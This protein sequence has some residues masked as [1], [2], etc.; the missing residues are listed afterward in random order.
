MCWSCTEKKNSRGCSFSLNANKST[1][2]RPNLAKASN[3]MKPDPPL[4]RTYAYGFCTWT[5]VAP[6]WGTKLVLHRFISHSSM[7]KWQG[8]CP[9]QW[10]PKWVI[11][12]NVTKG[13]LHLLIRHPGSRICPT[14][15]CEGASQPPT[16]PLTHT[17]KR[18]T[19]IKKLP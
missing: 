6:R 4:G 10:I 11:K 8:S 2:D 14:R 7:S 12:T 17:H 18:S 13:N 15:G 16:N 19:H 5:C 1:P 9:P 3:L